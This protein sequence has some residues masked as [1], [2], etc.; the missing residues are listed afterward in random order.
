MRILLKNGRLF[1]PASNLD[2]TGDVLLDEGKIKEL[3]GHITAGDAKEI[4]CQGKLIT[5]GLID[6]HVHL[7]EPGEEYKE[8][9]ESGTKAAAAGGFTAV[10]AMPNTNPVNDTR[11]VTDLIMEKARR[12][13]KARVYPVGAITKGLKGEELTEMYEL[14]EAGCVGVTDD[15][16]PVADSRMLRRAM[17]YALTF[18][19]AVV[20]HSE[21]KRLSAHGVMN[22]GPFATK[23]G[24]NGIPHE[25]EVLAVER[26]AALAVLTGARTHICH[27]SCA[28]SVE[29]VRRAKEKG[30]RITCET[31]PHYLTLIDE[32]V[33]NYDTHAKMN[34]PLRTAEDREAMC[35]GLADGTIDMVS[36][37][38][39]PHSIL[40]KDVEFDR[41]AFGVVGL[42]TSLG[43]ML[44]LVEKG[45]LTLEQMITRMSLAP[46][47]AFGLP[48]GKLE[49]NGPA[50]L[51][52]I[53]LNLP[54]VVKPELFL[55]KGR[56]T[57]FAGR[58]L[59]GRA[60][61]TICGGEITYTHEES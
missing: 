6:A 26:D 49:I 13:G 24:L 41:A 5:P 46:A 52:V 39:A 40:E 14:V 19:I 11:A 7:R 25:A 36:T 18:D 8:D 16:K 33:G 3:G 32:N 17:E 15:G 47:R 45:V 55:S 58:K 53:D 35:R 21:D 20:C 44:E 23:Y 38:H 51:T 22:E 29:A 28:G 27:L 57:P 61:L 34:P 4:D 42:E 31:A 30:G 9:I 59:P 56:N 12:L 60:V 48:G 43:I 1:C 54:W 50:D 37:D 10:A 2:E